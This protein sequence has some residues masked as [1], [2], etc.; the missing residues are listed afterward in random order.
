MSLAVSLRHISKQF[1]D[2]PTIIDDLSLEID[3]R[4]FLVILGASGCGKTTLLK[5]VAGL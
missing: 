3:P 2:G 5:I 1:D 4:E